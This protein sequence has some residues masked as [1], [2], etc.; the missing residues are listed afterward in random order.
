MDVQ[1]LADKLKLDWVN[2]QG[3]G[4]FYIGGY[5]IGFRIACYM[6]IELK[7]KISKLINLD[8]IIFKDH[9]EEKK[10]EQL[11]KGKY[12]KLHPNLDIAKEPILDEEPVFKN[13]YFN[14]KLTFPIIHFLCQDTL[15][16]KLEPTFCS[17]NNEIITIQGDHNSI[18]DFEINI[19]L[20]SDY[21]KNQISNS[22]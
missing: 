21:L 19:K 9:N 6:G 16:E 20:M 22:E 4:A 15:D 1:Q 18:L 12:E 3:T 10:I 5:S 8:G 14:E 2:E 11:F 13:D 17:D 7:K